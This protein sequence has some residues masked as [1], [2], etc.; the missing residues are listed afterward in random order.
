MLR[1]VQLLQQRPALRGAV[2][3]AGEAQ[4]EDWVGI[5]NDAV[6][7]KIAADE[8]G[9]FF[10]PEQGGFTTVDDATSFYLNEDGSVTLV[11]PEYSIA[12]G[13]AGIVEI[14]VVA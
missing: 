2:G 5:C 12:A 3:S 7:A 14:P 10:T 8:S 13:A 4:G 6:N 9:L 1:Q 11:F